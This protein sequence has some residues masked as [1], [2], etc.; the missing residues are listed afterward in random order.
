MNSLLQMLYINTYFRAAVYCWED[1]GHADEKIM[2]HLQV[3]FAHLQNSIES[4]FNPHE[5]TDL[6]NIKTNVQ[7]DAQEYVARC[8]VSTLFFASSSTF[9][10]SF[11]F[12]V[13][14]DHSSLLIATLPLS[15][16]ARASGMLT[17]DRF[18]KLFVSYLEGPLSHSR[19][20]MLK[21]LIEDQ[22]VGEMRYVTVCSKCKSK[23]MRTCKY[24]ELEL[25][26]VKV[27]AGAAPGCCLVCS[28][29]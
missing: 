18:F 6:L 10:I 16:P 26:I 29:V 14:I 2:H 3:L 15:V 4:S 20:P 27:R 24:Y 1:C 21:S 25:T 13:G 19:N 11:R 22:F 28:G 23:S 17:P 8:L 12:R 5:I 9:F 7:Q